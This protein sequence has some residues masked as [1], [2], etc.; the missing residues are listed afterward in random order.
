MLAPGL[1]TSGQAAPAT[2]N[3]DFTATSALNGTVSDVKRDAVTVSAV[4]NVT[5]TPNNTQQTFPGGSVVYTHVATNLGNTAETIS[6]AAGFLTD[7]RAG[8]G[9]TSLAYVD[10]NGNG[11]FDPGVDDVPANAISTATTIA[12][13]VNASRTIFVRVFAPGSAVGADPANVTTITARYNAGASSAAA[14]AASVSRAAA[15]ASG[16]SVVASW[17]RTSR[18][19]AGW[20][21]E[22]AL[23]G[24]MPWLHAW[25][26][27]AA[28]GSGSSGSACSASC[29]ARVSW[30]RKASQSPR[31]WPAARLAKRSARSANTLALTGNRKDAASSAGG[32]KSIG[33]V[34]MRT[35]KKRG[36]QR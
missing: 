2:Y 35:Q 25:A 10:G 28:S 27:V 11:V 31:L 30:P 13:G 8:Q 24:G 9:W 22:L 7:S 23:R 36:A 26:S 32:W 29:W 3:L 33:W 18:Q 5:L 16:P 17:R 6:F 14:R 1:T 19:M 21:S 12:L 4:N 34:C 15:G 20:A